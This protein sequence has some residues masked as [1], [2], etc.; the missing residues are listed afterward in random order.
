ME[1]I[2]IYRISIWTASL[3]GVLIF[4]FGNSLQ[5]A[6]VSGEESAE[7]FSH[8][9]QLFPF[10]THH[11]VRK[12]AHFCEYALLG[13]HL[14]FA[15]LT[16][17]ARGYAMHVTSLLFG[18]LVALVDEGI[19]RF[20]PGRAGMLTDALIDYAGY[21][22]GFLLFFGLIFLYVKRKGNRFEKP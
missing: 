14:A 13:A 2:R 19:Q 3:L 8:L 17:P 4:V 12:L 16:L 20:V 1:N 6:S 5:P 11:L 22:C 9:S 7:V 10:L 18:A 21:L 15:P